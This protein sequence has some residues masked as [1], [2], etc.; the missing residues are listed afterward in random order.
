MATVFSATG[1]TIIYPSSDGEPLAE[2]SVHIDAIIAIVVALR[3][4]LKDQPA[5][6]LADQFLYYAQ[7][8]PKLRVAPDVMVIYDVQPGPRDNYKIWEEQQIPKVIFEVTSAGT[9]EQDQGLK[10]GLYEQ[11]GVQEY[12]LFDP[13]GEWIPEQL[14]GYRL[15]GERYQLIDDRS[16]AILNLRLEVEQQVLVFYRQDTGAKL[17]L[18]DELGQKLQSEILARQQAEARAQSAEDQVAILRDKLRAL[19]I[20]P[21][22]AT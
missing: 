1:S 13:R 2:T 11:L 17:L 8:F 5:I 9:R 12:W 4:Y 20:D 21:D 6:I 16:S 22:S 7:G 3:L 15:Q 18:T 14:Q 19:G 10:K